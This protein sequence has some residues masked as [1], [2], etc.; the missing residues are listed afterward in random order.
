MEEAK[1]CLQEEGLTSLQIIFNVLRQ[2]PAEEIFS[3]AKEKGVALIVRL[4]LASGLLAG[5]INQDT[6][7]P[8]NDH[9]NFN[10]NGEQFIVGETFSGLPLAR[11]LELLQDM[12]D[13][14]PEGMNLGQMA[15]L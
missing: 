13:L 6:R 8:D 15:L 9:R 1:I 14:V 7:F 11:G 4:P 3:E 10:Q 12:K 2:K 5:K